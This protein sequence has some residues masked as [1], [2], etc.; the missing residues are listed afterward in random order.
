MQYE[1]YNVLGLQNILL[2]VLY[3]LE[4]ALTSL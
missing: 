3:G 1:V 2:Q 4:L